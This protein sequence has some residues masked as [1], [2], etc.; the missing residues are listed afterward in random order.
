MSCFI[1]LYFSEKKSTDM[2]HS[3]WNISLCIFYITFILQLGT[4]SNS[5][6]TT[7]HL[8]KKGMEFSPF[9]QQT[10]LLEVHTNSRMTCG[11]QCLNTRHC[12]IFNFD[13]QT[14]RC[15]LYEG[16]INITGSIISSSSSSQSICGSLIS[17]P[18]DFVN[19]GHSCSDCTDDHYLT[20]RNTTCQCYTHEY[21]DGQIC[22][23]QKLN[24]SVCVN[25]NECRSDMN[26]TCGM[27]G[28]CGS[29]YQFSLSYYK[30]Y[31][32]YEDVH[33]FP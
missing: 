16:D 29:E 25:D 21:F 20:C 9:D 7:I 14:S 12:H 5:R 1:S 22:R 2:V 10:M 3:Y 19:Y 32:D 18:A 17:I 28:E 30:I 27:N 11:I 24:G 33:S 23:S 8:F 13:I 4:S 31:F 15:R 26:L 6:R